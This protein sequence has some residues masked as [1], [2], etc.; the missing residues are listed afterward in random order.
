MKNI[1]LDCGTHL[2]EGLIT[3]Y[4]SGIINDSFE[5]HTFEANPACNAG[6]RVKQLPLNINFYEAAVWTQDGFVYFNQENHKNSK[7]GSPTDG[8]SDIDGWASSVDG[9]GFYYAQYSTQ[10]KVPSIDF[11]RFIS[12]LPEDSNIIC[13]MDI[14]GSEFQVLRHLI[15]KQTITKIK[16]IY[17]EFHEKLMSIESTETKE[18]LIRQIENLGVKVHTWF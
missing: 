11:S 14:E 7:S 18:E 3:F 16:E 12:E 2:C 1:F 5:I 8:H 17:I 9:L 13:K 6:E 4:N 15:Q 10:V